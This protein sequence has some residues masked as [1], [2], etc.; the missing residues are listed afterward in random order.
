M[1]Q[2]AGVRATFRNRVLVERAVERR[3]VHL[4]RLVGSRA[5]ANLGESR[6]IDADPVG[7]QNAGLDPVAQADVEADD[8][9][10]RVDALEVAALADARRLALIATVA[11]VLVTRQHGPAGR[12]R[13]G[14]DRSARKLARVAIGADERAVGRAHRGHG[15]EAEIA[16]GP[17]VDLLDRSACGRRSARWP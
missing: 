2:A 17:R 5:D 14:A 3:S 10:A 15:I 4:D 8:R 12:R 7:R 1:N 13:G 11:K 6:G 9:I 16:G